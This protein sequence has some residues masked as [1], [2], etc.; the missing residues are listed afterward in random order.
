MNLL[1]L[2]PESI[3]IG[4]PL[5]YALRDETG[6]LLARRGYI[7]ASRDDLD[8]MRGRGQ[9]FFIDVAESERHQK[10]YVGKLYDLVRD[11][12]P[13]GQIAEARL[14]TRDLG[15]DR[16]P[17]AEGMTNWLDIQ[18]QGTRLLRDL[19]PETFHNHL[20]HLHQRLAEE[21]R[22]NPDG[23]LFALFHLASR[24]LRY[25]SATHAML[26]AM[27]CTL[28]AREVLGWEDELTATLG[29]AA[30]TMNI[31]MTSLQDGLAAQ[32]EPPV[33]EQR[34]LIAA[35]PAQGAQ[36]LQDMGITDSHW[37]EAVRD[38]HATSAGPLAPRTPAQRMARLIQRADMFVARLAPRASRRAQS[39]AQAMQ[40]CYF[41]E[42]RATD[43][44]GAAL[45]K[46]VGVYSP[47]SLVR[48]ANQEVGM[49]VR[50]GANTT[51]P[52]VAIVLNRDGFATGEYLLRD[53]SQR[54]L[55]VASTIPLHESR[56]EINLEKMLA[57]TAGAGSGRLP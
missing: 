52:R 49:V 51:S 26:V 8:A 21:C 53:T 18:V 46:A 17:A 12:R 2:T 13:L 47:G 31:A 27:V 57:L 6:V 43:E 4:R 36:M 20:N 34:R 56:V 40:A 11:E 14:S 38:H 48:L 9:G 15:L 16:R 54:E 28:A 45:I 44:A 41:D 55:R 39:N 7:I 37:L 24:E 33:A 29:K 19:H 25:Y 22:R 3:T 1:E 35:H 50:R 30:M 10:A 5:P 32:L 23:T 42:N